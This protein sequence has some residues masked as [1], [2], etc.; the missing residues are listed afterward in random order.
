MSH[1]TTL[2]IEI[3]D[4]AA[5]K[6]AC[7][8]VGLEFREGQGTYK[9]FGRH[10]GDYPLP[11]GFKKGDLGK[12]DHAIGVK[13]KK[14]AYEIGVCKRDGKYVLLWDFWQ[15]GYG[16]QEVAGRDCSNLTTAYTKNV[17]IKEA[18][19]LASSQGYTVSE[20]VDPQT[21]ETIITLR[22]Y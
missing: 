16:L 21:N 7:K 11:E 14:D 9:W 20:E 5:L 4:L 15:G 1:V 22:K 18:K 6:D 12:C 8:K 3:K 17:A 13:G 2:K 10:V 19:K